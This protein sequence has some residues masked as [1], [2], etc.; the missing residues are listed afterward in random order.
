MRSGAKQQRG[1]IQSN[2]DY[3]KDDDPRFLMRLR[4]GDSAAYRVLVRRFHAS[5]VRFAAS[6]IGSHAQPRR[7]GSVA[8][9]SC[10]GWL[11]H[12]APARLPG[13]QHRQRTAPGPSGPRRTT[14]R[15]ER[16]LRAPTWPNAFRLPSSP[17][18]HWTVWWLWDE[19]NPDKLS[20]TPALGSRAG[21]DRPAARRPARAVSVARHGSRDAEWKPGAVLEISAENQRAR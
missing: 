16:R 13:F 15:V 17:D 10:G 1:Q 6:I 12:D 11:L 21:R 9:G 19:L 20:W 8:G 14:C 7:S 2:G 5:L 18:G 3:R 4:Q